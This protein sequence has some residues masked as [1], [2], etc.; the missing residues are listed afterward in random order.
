MFE[1]TSSLKE[2]KR[3]KLKIKKIKITMMF[4][5]YL[6]QS[7]TFIV[8]LTF[9]GLSSFLRTWIFSFDTNRVPSKL[10]WPIN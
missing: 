6:M 10:S 9:A 2:K 3:R 7:W 8:Q 1:G 4:D 5:R